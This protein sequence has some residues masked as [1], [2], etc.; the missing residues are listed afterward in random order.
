MK[1]LFF[2]AFLSLLAV[3]CGKY[4]EGPGISLL[5]KK[6]RI[7]NVWSLSSRMTNSQTTNLSNSTWK[8]E[9]KDDETYSSQAT[10][11]GIPF[12]NESGIWKFS[13]DKSQLLTT[14]SGSSNTDSWE[15]I[16]LTKEELKLKYISGGDTIVDTFIGQ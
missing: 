3:S 16:R 7:T 11:L 15:I 8:V 14:P 10:Y 4:E 13:T 2:I 5:S 9:I 1:K 12:L 6:N